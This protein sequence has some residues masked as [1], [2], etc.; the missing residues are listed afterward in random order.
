[1]RQARKVMRFPKTATSVE[2]WMRVAGWIG[3]GLIL[4]VS[5]VPGPERPHTGLSGQM[6]HTIAYLMTATAYSWSSSRLQE[7][8]AW[9]A[10]LSAV[11]GGLEVCQL[12][13]PGRNGQV[14][15]WAAS[16]FGA[17]I[18]TILGWLARTIVSQAGERRLSG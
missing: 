16:S 2:Q 6:E 12:V 1:M 13:I 17:S 8:L 7:R 3:L 14:I 18:G 11:S 4:I 10:F 5:L 15:D 9:L